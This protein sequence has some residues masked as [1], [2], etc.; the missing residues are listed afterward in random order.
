MVWV[1]EEGVTWAAISLMKKKQKAVG[2]LPATVDAIAPKDVAGGCTKHAMVMVPRHAA[3][4][5]RN[6]GEGMRCVGSAACS[7]PSLD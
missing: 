2:A 7:S 4:K 5:S 1:V 3:E 6:C